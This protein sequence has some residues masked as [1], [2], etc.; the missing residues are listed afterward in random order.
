MDFH[1]S[2]HRFASAGWDK[3]VRIW[4]VQTGRQVAAWEAGTEVIYRVVYSPDGKLLAT[5][6]Q[7]GTVRIWDASRKTTRHVIQSPAAVFSVAF[8]PDGKRIVGVSGENNALGSPAVTLWDVSTGR[9][10]FTFPENSGLLYAVRFSLDGTRILTANPAI[11][12]LLRGDAAVWEAFPWEAEAYAGNDEAPFA[13][14]VDAYARRYWEDRLARAELDRHENPIVVRRGP[15]N[16]PSRDNRT[17]ADALDL[18]AFYN[19]SLSASLLPHAKIQDEGND[20]TSLPVGFVTLANTPLD[21]RGVIQTANR[22]WTDWLPK[23]V[24]GIPLGRVFHRLHV[25]H[26]TA[27]RES[28]GTAIGS[29]RLNYADGEQ[30]DIPLKYGVDVRD[31]HFTSGSPFQAEQ[32]MIAW[33]GQNLRTASSGTTLRL[34]KSVIENPRPRTEVTSV[35]Y[36]SRLTQCAP[37]LIAIT[38]DAAEDE[39]VFYQDSNK[40]LVDAFLAQPDETQAR[41]QLA[42]SWKQLGQAVHGTPHAQAA[43]AFH[44]LS[45]LLVMS[46]ITKPIRSQKMLM[47]RTQEDLSG[48]AHEDAEVSSTTLVAEGRKWRYWDRGSPPPPHWNTMIFDDAAWAEGYAPLGYGEQNLATTIGF[49]SDEQNKH[50]TTYFRRTFTLD[51]AEQVPLA[52]LKVTRDD[53]VIVYLNGEEL[54]RDNLPA[55]V[56]ANTFASTRQEP[57]ELEWLVP[58]A[59]LRSGKNVIA[60]EIHQVNRTS[61]DVVFRLELDALL[62]PMDVEALASR[63]IGNGFHFPPQLKSYLRR[64]RLRTGGD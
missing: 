51:D 40:Y 12:G 41:L 17:P 32:A 54:V 8:S 36:A 29:L 44:E 31:W 25:L 34:Y 3:S 59:R 33:T 15:R 57:T 22:V 20:L 56:N 46:S 27:Y 42:D 35:D 4:D 6:G 14:R 7:D 53:G 23:E 45:I 16:W 47:P 43:A 18:T 58:S 5:A 64:P 10:V 61:S 38:V 52:R 9:Q 21:I 26:G 49:G 19:R 1:Y 28:N 24:S 48:D 37:F 50:V 13:D 2:G 63:L 55:R 39:L 30:R 60:A 62:L 11:Q